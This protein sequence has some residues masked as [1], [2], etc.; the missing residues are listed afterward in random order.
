MYFIIKTINLPSFSLP[1]VEPIE[2]MAYCKLPPPTV[3]Y[4]DLSAAKF[5]HSHINRMYIKNS[6]SY[7]V[8]VGTGL[9]KF[10]LCTYPSPSILAK[11]L[12]VTFFHP[13]AYTSLHKYIRHIFVPSIFRDNYR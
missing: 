9:Q 4:L 13:L 1:L 2:I 6:M 5:M 10:K 12:A 7:C 11:L 3:L 8:T